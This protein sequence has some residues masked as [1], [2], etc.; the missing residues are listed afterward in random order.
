MQRRQSSADCMLSGSGLLSELWVSGSGAKDPVQGHQCLLWTPV[1]PCTAWLCP[2]ELHSGLV[3]LAAVHRGHPASCC[4]CI[5]TCDS[6][7]KDFSPEPQV[8]VAELLLL[9]EL[10]KTTWCRKAS[11]GDHWSPDCLTHARDQSLLSSAIL[12]FWSKGY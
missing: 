6:D 11:Q 3:D 8:R 5:L 7:R 4:I 9:W 1:D 12:G 10:H 2:L